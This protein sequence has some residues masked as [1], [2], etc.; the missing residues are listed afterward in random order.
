VVLPFSTEG[1][2]PDALAEGLA[3]DLIGRLNSF[4]GLQAILKRSVFS[5]HGKQLSLREI[6]ASLK[7]GAAL[8]LA[9]RRQPE[10]LD[11]EVRLV[12]FP[13][14]RE[15]WAR[16]YV[17]PLTEIFVVQGDIAAHAAAELKERPAHATRKWP[18]EKPEAYAAYLRGR[19]ALSRIDG[20]RTALEFFERAV[21]LDPSYAQAH[22]GI[23]EAYQELNFS[24]SVRRSEAY[25]KA[26]RAVQQSLAINES[27]PEAHLAAGRIK[28]YFEWDWG[29]CEQECRRA[30]EL[31]PSNAEGH[32]RYGLVLALEG[33]FDEA[34]NRLRLA[35]SLD[36]LSPR[37][38]WVLASTLYWARRYDAAIAEARRILEI[39]P[40]YSWAYYT[41]GQCYAEIGKLDEAITAF[42]RAAKPVG[43]LGNAYA[44]AGEIGELRKVLAGIEKRSREKGKANSVGLAM[45]YSGLG[46]VD[47]AI[48]Q[49]ERAYE[50]RGWLG[51]LKVAPVWDPLRSS[52]RFGKLL[53][54]VGLAETSAIGH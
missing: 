12:R 1:T 13:E 33:R 25:P 16:R 46:D 10:T 5:L 50:D 35:E 54:K 19:S 52:P 47:R 28:M 17:R 3:E 24:G 9:V 41:L 11:L 36:P 2:R 6:G 45:I 23:A 8:T 44:R 32:E 38:G 18:T 39:D 43:N 30:I 21:A 7:A 40:Q 14:G 53:K 15:L 26:L 49:L 34:L 20:T 51:T 29:G 27:L 4:K 42:G 48:D 22:A 31:D 37:T